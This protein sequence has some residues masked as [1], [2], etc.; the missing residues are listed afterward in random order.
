MGRSDLPDMYARAQGLTVPEGR[1]GHIRR[2]KTA[3][4][5]YVMCNTSGIPKIALHYIGKD[6]AFDYGT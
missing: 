1:C 4:V 6:G 3:H 2:I 5:T